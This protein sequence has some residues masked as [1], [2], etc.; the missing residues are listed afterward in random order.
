MAGYL[1]M[2]PK[3]RKALPLLILL[4]FCVIPFIFDTEKSYVI[5]FL[6]LAFIY[7]A[8]SQAWNLIAGYTGQVSWASCLLRNWCLCDRHDMGS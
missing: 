5:Y 8:L 3:V 2:S 7:I 6:F 4:A 1:D